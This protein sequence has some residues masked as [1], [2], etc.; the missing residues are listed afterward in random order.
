M[1]VDP[2][3]LTAD[4]PPPPEMMSGG[5]PTAV[6]ALAQFLG[7]SELQYQKVQEFATLAMAALQ[8]FMNPAMQTADGPMGPMPAEDDPMG[9]EPMGE[10][11]GEMG[12]EYPPGM[13][14]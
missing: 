14:Y 12:Q 13:G 2:A 3:M 5:Q 8:E 1:A 7:E 9:E 10:P 6:Q 11:A 4:G